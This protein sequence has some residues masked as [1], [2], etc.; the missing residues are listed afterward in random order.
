MSGNVVSLVEA[1]PTHYKTKAIA[2]ATLPHWI[3]GGK[4]AGVHARA[5]GAAIRVYPGDA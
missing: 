1:V 4:I 5:E 2:R 3:M